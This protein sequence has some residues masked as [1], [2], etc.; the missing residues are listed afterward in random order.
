M[1]VM[2]PGRDTAAG[3]AAAAAR[4]LP[5]VQLHSG[6]CAQGRMPRMAHWDKT[7]STV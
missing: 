3:A 2:Q 4:W 6:C 1:A 5:P 7:L